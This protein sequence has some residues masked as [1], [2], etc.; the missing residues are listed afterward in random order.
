M[1][2]NNV[3][4]RID[5][6]NY[7]KNINEE[8]NAQELNFTFFNCEKKEK[9]GGQKAWAIVTLATLSLIP[10]WE[11]NTLCLNVSGPGL[12][13]LP[14]PFKKHYKSKYGLLFIGRGAASQTAALK[15]V[16]EDLILQALHALSQI[17]PKTQK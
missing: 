8:E 1:F 2:S 5:E 9:S 14:T 7:F 6:V 10:Y 11:E 3:I 16:Q 15:P 13:P 4:R 12:Q 17:L